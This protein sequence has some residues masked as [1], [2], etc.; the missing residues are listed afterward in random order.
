MNPAV[1]PDQSTLDKYFNLRSY[2]KTN[3]PV[4]QTLASESFGNNR[5]TGGSTANKSS[6]R[7]LR[8][9]SKWVDLLRDVAVQIQTSSKNGITYQDLS[10]LRFPNQKPP[11]VVIED[12]LGDETPL[13]KQVPFDIG[14]TVMSGRPLVDIGTGINPVGYF[15]SARMHA[16]TYIALEPFHGNKFLQ[17]LTLC[18]KTMRTSENLSSPQAL[19]YNQHANEFLK[20]IDSAKTPVNFLI[21]QPQFAG[22]E[23]TT[24]LAQNLTRVMDKEGVLFIQMSF[25]DPNQQ[26]AYL[27]IEELLNQNFKIGFKEVEL[28]GQKQTVIMASYHLPE[29]WYDQQITNK[30]TN[31]DQILTLTIDE[32]KAK[33]N[34]NQ[35]SLENCADDEL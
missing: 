1:T 7:D 34:F 8:T 4:A 18:Q 28:S 35:T 11:R 3:E 5:I 12:L 30:K 19:F 15:I 13:N 27:L 20:K 16:S 21:R 33:A 25:T 6:F 9:L 31:S 22:G 26:V 29:I 14:S 17:N 2:L 10:I 32:L 24:L 23:Y